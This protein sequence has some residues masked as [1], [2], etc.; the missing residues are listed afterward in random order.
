M[1]SRYTITHSALCRDT[2]AVFS[3]APPALPAT[4]PR[5]FS[6][7]RWN[8]WMLG[9]WDVLLPSTPLTGGPGVRVAASWL[10]RARMMAAAW[11]FNFGYLKYLHQV[12]R[13]L[14]CCFHP[15]DHVSVKWSGGVVV[16]ISLP[17]YNAAT[18]GGNNDTALQLIIMTQGCL[19]TQ[20]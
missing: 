15:S 12:I 20:P 2:V 4:A 1:D 16:T 13:R 5:Q 14:V 19:P 6:V 17:L 10:L 3:A 9:C 7:R 11:H 8:C 18:V